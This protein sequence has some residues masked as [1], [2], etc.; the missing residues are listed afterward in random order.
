MLAKECL[1]HLTDEKSFL[2]MGDLNSLRG[3]LI[4]DNTAI[5]EKV[6]MTNCFNRLK[7]YRNSW[8]MEKGLGSPDKLIDIAGSDYDQYCFAMSQCN[9]IINEM[10]PCLINELMTAYNLHSRINMTRLVPRLRV[11]HI[12]PIAL[13]EVRRFVVHGWHPRSIRSHQVCQVVAA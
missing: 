11:L 12:Y 3:K 10:I 1:N 7:H 13:P 4:M 8:N 9:S 2:K 5:Y 6:M